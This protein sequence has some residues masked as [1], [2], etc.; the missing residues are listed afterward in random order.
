MPSLADLYRELGADY[1]LS[2]D[3]KTEGVESPILAVGRRGRRAGAALAVLPQRLA[4]AR[5]SASSR[6]R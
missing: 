4:A 5:R 3:V 1:E 6:R 2:I